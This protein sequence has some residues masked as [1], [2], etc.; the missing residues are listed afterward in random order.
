MKA[1]RFLNGLPGIILAILAAAAALQLYV[2][3]REHRAVER[4]AWAQT[5]DSLRN[6][7]VAES[8]AAEARDRARADS[9]TKLAARLV[10][11]VTTATSEGR[12][13][14]VFHDALHVLVD[15]NVAAKAA[16]DSLEAAHAS[17]VMSLLRAVALADSIHQ[18]DEAEKAD[19]RARLVT[20]NT[21]LAAAIATADRFEHRA[22]PGALRRVLDSPVT[23][24]VAAGLGYVAGSAR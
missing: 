3:E 5:R 17:Q 13:A 11:A 16:L 8:L 15:S 1:L 21:R 7:I 2:R 9:I 6:V 10:G 24:L 23:H 19:L 12:R 22:N 20:V 14:V 18:V 4:A